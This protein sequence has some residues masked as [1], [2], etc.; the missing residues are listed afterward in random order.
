MLSTAFAIL[1]L[2]RVV[3]AE[4]L[5]SGGDEW[6]FRP[7]GDDKPTVQYVQT[8]NDVEGS[9]FP[10]EHVL[11]DDVGERDFANDDPGTWSVYYSGKR[12]DPWIQLDLGSARGILA[13]QIF[14]HRANTLCDLNLV[15]KY[16]EGCT[17]YD[18]DG[19]RRTDIDNIYYTDSA[20]DTN[21]YDI[22]GTIIGVGLTQP[23][24]DLGS[25]DAATNRATRGTWCDNGFVC[26]TIDSHEK[27]GFTVNNDGTVTKQATSSITVTW[28]AALFAGLVL[29]DHVSPPTDE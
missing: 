22:K 24:D 1:A 17:G 4:V 14:G 15:G 11:D 27:A 28:Y 20:T 16:P 18:P 8:V 7:W 9:K 2:A 6:N 26:G 21:E 5:L 25:D 23:C 13:I 29:H 10:P 12:N 19:S 3:D